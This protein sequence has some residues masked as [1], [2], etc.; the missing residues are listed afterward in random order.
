M[1][2]TPCPTPC[3]PAISQ[4]YLA[5]LSCP[6]LSSSPTKLSVLQNPAGSLKSP[7]LHFLL[8]VPMATVSPFCCSVTKSCPT[9]CHSMDCSMLASLSVTLSWSLLKLM[10][11]ELVMRSNHFILSCPLLFWPSIFPSIRV[12]STE[13]ALCIRWP[14]YWCFSFSISP[15]SKYLGLI[16]FRID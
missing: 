16:S 1:I 2:T 12:F 9:L 10:C 13:S 6:L 11:L 4:P 8:P 5:S 14:K 15:S 7:A 3:C